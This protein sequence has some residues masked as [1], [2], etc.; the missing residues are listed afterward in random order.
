MAI[1]WTDELAT[2]VSIIDEQHRELFRRINSLL[3]ACSCGR[4]K[5][6]LS[7]VISF[8]EEYV[9]THFAEEEARMRQY[10]YPDYPAHKALHEEFNRNFSHLREMFMADGPAVHVVIKTNQ[11]VV[12]W[13]TAHIKRVDK[14]L[15]A[16]LKS[17]PQAGG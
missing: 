15:G 12:E 17:R 11:V 2:G 4:G 3:D 8:L 10:N 1:Q 6:E 16:F 14:A 5:S 7:T 9:A 13:L